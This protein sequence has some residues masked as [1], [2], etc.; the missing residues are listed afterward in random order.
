MRRRPPRS[1][2][3]PYTTLFRSAGR[4]SGAGGGPVGAGAAAGSAVEG[5]SLS[6]TERD[7]TARAAWRTERASIDPAQLVFVDECGTH[8]S[9]TRRRA[10]ARRGERA[11]GRV[12]R[13]RGPG[14]NLLAGVSP[15]GMVT[16][17]TR[18]GGT[19]TPGFATHV[20]HFVVH[21]L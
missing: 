2:L 12:P 10:R 14:T 4:R 11:R 15:A 7:E 21:P 1:T 9:R 19:D 18:G 17:V 16:R 20:E 13:N 6:A 3:F 5:K 8:T